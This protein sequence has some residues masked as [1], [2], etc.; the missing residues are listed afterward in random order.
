MGRIHTCNMNTATPFMKAPLVVGAVV[1][2]RDPQHFL[3]EFVR[4]HN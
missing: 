2:V 4:R 1:V 3:V